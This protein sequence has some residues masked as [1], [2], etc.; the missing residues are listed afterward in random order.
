MSEIPGS[1]FCKVDL[2][3]HTPAS[4]DFKDKQATPEDIVARAIETGLYAIGITDHNTIIWVDLIRSASS[5]SNLIVFPGFELNAKG[6][7]I[8]ALFDP[9]TP[10]DVLETALI[11]AGIPKPKWGDNNALAHDIPIALQ[12]ITHNGGLAIAAHADGDKGFLNTIRQGVTRIQVFMNPD[13]SAIE[14][15]TPE[16]KADY[17]TGKVPGYNRC[18]ACIQGSDAHSIAEIGTKP[19]FL[20]MHRICEEGLRQAFSEPALRIHF[21]EDV[22]P[23]LYPQIES[24]SIDQGF[25]AGQEIPFNPSLNCLVGGAG[26]GKSTIIEFVRFALDQVSPFEDIAKDVEG[27]LRDLAG[28]GTTIRL[29][30]R[31]ESG[32]KLEIARTFDDDL[33]PIILTDLST[34][35]EID[36]TDIRSLFPIHAFSQ[37]EVVAISR[38]PLAQLDLIDSHL[39]ISQ[40][41]EEIRSAYNSLAQQADGLVRLEAVSRDR[42]RIQNEIATV[43]TQANLLTAELQSLEEAQKREV[44]TSHQFW[45]AEDA[46]FRD[47]LDSFQPTKSAIENGIQAIDLSLPNIPIPHEVTPN[48][49]Q[50]DQCRLLA[51]QMDQACMD[52]T[53]LLMERLASI[54]KEIRSIYKQWDKAYKNHNAQYEKLQ[55]GEK[56][57]RIAQ[58]NNQLGNL[59]KKLQGFHAKIKSIDA[60]DLTF[61]RQLKE[62][63]RLLKLIQDRKARIFALRERK[64]KEFVKQIGDTIALSLQA[65]G[66]R[67]QYDDLLT[68]IMRGTYAPRSIST[69]IAHTIHPMDLA[70]LI[71]ASDSKKI[72]QASRIGEKWA[73]ALLDQVKANPAY[74]YQIEASPIED[75]IEISFKLGEGEYRPIDKLSTGQKA[76]VIVLLTM[77]EGNK[78][79]IFDQ[80]EDALYTPFIYT[81]V[82]RSIRREKDQRQ[83]ILATHNPN[84]AV[85][86]DTD[87]GII[88]E[89]TS[90]NA[91]V[92]AAG[93]LDDQVTQG[94]LLWHLEGGEQA[95][96]SRQR[97]F[98]LK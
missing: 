69:D 71:R 21:P 36:I 30:I 42:D 81:D 50:L 91:M 67:S 53:T 41:R 74:A 11:E 8:L 83:F 92:Q 24:M 94:L 12:A 35:Q 66:N 47:L 77:V 55:I 84:I 59:R 75:F 86:G 27:K 25:L 16:R 5:S 39:D 2:H 87:L 10:L 56:S 63:E 76:T 34:E 40:F 80:P 19:V 49:E 31:L 20:R 79:I 28:I 3:I 73:Q 37:G 44:V 58:I 51:L 22:F 6:G 9:D 70:V 32:D 46:Y 88:L 68:Q 13:L 14:L 65:D 29:R 90:T 48:R 61:G 85:G 17:I 45:I 89:G 57:A 18:M 52:A 26:S 97:K 98:G 54:E 93:G 43:K 23:A 15:V 7:H 72:D 33:N 62:R 1:K 60:A 95:L 78:P 4:S 38:N 96:K 82:V 64:S